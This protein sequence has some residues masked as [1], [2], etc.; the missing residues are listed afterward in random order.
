MTAIQPM[1]V[2]DAGNGPLDDIIE[3]Q[4]RLLLDDIIE[5]PQ[6]LLLDDIIEKPRK[7]KRDRNEMDDLLWASEEAQSWL[8]SERE[9]ELLQ[10]ADKTA[11]EK[12]WQLQQMTG[13]KTLVRRSERQT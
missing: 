11:K 12:G 3:K 5:K 2:T 1:V 4:Q 8:Y 13:H 6:R 9:R 10:R 7:R